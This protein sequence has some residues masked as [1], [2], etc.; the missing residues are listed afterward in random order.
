ME[1]NTAWKSTCKILLGDEI[2]ELGEYE[3][4]LRRYTKRI[5]KRKSS[6]SGKDVSF[7]SPHVPG[8]AKVISYDELEQYK[9]KFG[10]MA[11]NI[12]EL[13]DID[14]IVEA[15]G[16][17]FYYSGNIILGKSFNV[18]SVD[19][20][21]NSSFVSDSVDVYDSKF[22]AYSSTLRYSENVFGSDAVGQGTRF[23]INGYDVYELA[24]GFETIR[25]F[26]SS[27]C[28]YSGNLEGCS[29]CMF[30]FN[31]RKQNYCIGNLSLSREKYAKLRGKLL[32]DIQ[33]TLRSKKDVI[34]IID[35]IGDAHER[36]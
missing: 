4:Y 24:R 16:E 10:K 3:A 27:D 11:V 25:V 28:Y 31:L 32:E 20:C 8:N 12:N 34:S 15:L 30:S 7:T 23:C 26:V 14:S 9:T 35:L 1:L 33:E 19:R 17:Q 18:E 22:V 36:N 2:G 5:Q 13:K 6:F 29:N 21:Y